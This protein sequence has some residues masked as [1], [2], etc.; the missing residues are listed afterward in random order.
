MLIKASAPWEA[1]DL[2]VLAT[3]TLAS[4]TMQSVNAYKL[5]L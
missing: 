3:Y 2:S 1:D 4:L 5:T